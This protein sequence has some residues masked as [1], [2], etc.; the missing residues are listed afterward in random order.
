MNQN[1]KQAELSQYFMTRGFFS[2]ED[3]KAQMEKLASQYPEVKAQEEGLTT[4]VDRAYAAYKA[5]NQPAA[6]T[7]GT[8]TQVMPTA[9][10]SD[11]D[12]AFINSK[13][14]NESAVRKQ[15]TRGTRIVRLLLGK[16]APDSYIAEG[17]TGILKVDAFK[18]ILEKIENGTYTVQPDDDASATNAIA[19]TTNF[20]TL[21]AA[22]ANPEQNPLAVYVGKMNTRPVGYVVNT[23]DSVGSNASDK[24][25]TRA[26]FEK[27]MVLETDGYVLAAS[28][29]APGAMLRYI[30]PKAD[31]NNPGQVKPGRTVVVDKNK[32][33]AIANG[34]YDIVTA[35]VNGSSVTATGKSALAFKVLVNGKTTSKGEPIVRTIRVSLEIKVPEFAV[36]DVYADQ[37]EVKHDKTF[38]EELDNKTF[39]KIRDAQ[40]KA[41]ADLTKALGSADTSLDEYADDIQKYMPQSTQAPNVAV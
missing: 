23:I 33:E 7:Q 27:F 37:F 22:M 35:A 39:G 24:A 19:S 3:Q 28:A 8:P 15:K 41:I 14:R 29:T 40:I 36:K 32:K 6:P 11:A 21:K 2:E 31:T 13:L 26:K 30:D 34:A 17:A 9:S 12:K 20:N 25:M 5:M 10:I 16:P 1:E 38:T 18:N 4:V